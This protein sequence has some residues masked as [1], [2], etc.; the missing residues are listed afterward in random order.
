MARGSVA[1]VAVVSVLDL[2]PALGSGV[3]SEEWET[4]RRV[5]RAVL[6]RVPSG[7]RVPPADA[8]AGDLVGLV[9]VV[10][11]VC[12]ELALRDRRMLELLGPGDVVHPPG[13]SDWPRLGTTTVGTAVLDTEFLALGGPFIAAAARWPCL[14]RGVQDRLESQRNRLAVQGLIAHLPRAEHRL[15]LVLHHLADRWGF[16]SPEGTVVPLPLS[17]DM[18]AQLAAARRSTITLAIS[19][20]ERGGELRRLEDGSWLLTGPAE[21]L[22]QAIATTSASTQPIGEMLARRA[23][24]IEG[25]Q[26]ARALRAEA[27]LARHRPRP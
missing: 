5:C 14:L 26:D 20:L 7:G 4:A 15:L 12:R 22:V 11:L 2:D 8:L 13:E 6:V 27:R 10:G 23:R 16:V 21:E 18:L 9:L 24:T 1:G 17:H 3:S 19:T 25:V